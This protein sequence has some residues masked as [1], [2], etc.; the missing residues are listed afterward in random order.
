MVASGVQVRCPEG[1]TGPDGRACGAE[2]GPGAYNWMLYHPADRF[3]PFQYIEA[4]I[5]TALAVLLLL[6]AI[7]RVRR[8]A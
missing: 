4:G 7:W 6:L 8:I 3:W 5:F 1:A 2:F